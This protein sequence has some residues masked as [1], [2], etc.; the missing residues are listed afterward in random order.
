[1]YLR[2]FR[3]FDHEAPVQHQPDRL[4]RPLTENAP[5]GKGGA[6][7]AVLMAEQALLKALQPEGWEKDFTTFFTLSGEVLTSLMALCTACS[8]DGV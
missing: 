7:F 8:V 6:A 2:F 1:M 4:P 5:S 3:L